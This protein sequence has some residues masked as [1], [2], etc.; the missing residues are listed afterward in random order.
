MVVTTLI[1]SLTTWWQI[2]K[3]W[4]WLVYDKMWYN[5]WRCDWKWRLFRMYSTSIN[6]VYAFFEWAGPLHL[7]TNHYDLTHWTIQ[8]SVR[9]NLSDL[10]LSLSNR[11]V[12]IGG[13]THPM[14]EWW[15]NRPD[16]VVAGCHQ[17]IMVMFKML[18]M[19]HCHGIETMGGNL[20]ICFY[21]NI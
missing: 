10:G 12:V 6:A 4:W 21:S 1:K 14:I 7:I 8:S 11:R 5:V 9:W 15:M 2:Q 16:E 17:L 3:K 20:S 13:S 19:Y 18:S